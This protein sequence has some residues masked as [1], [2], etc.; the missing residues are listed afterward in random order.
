MPSVDGAQSDPADDS[1]TVVPIEMVDPPLG[2]PT[3]GAKAG[4][5]RGG[6]RARASRSS[7]GPA[8]PD[9]IFEQML[10]EGLV[11]TDAAYA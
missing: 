7:T 11:A 6:G 8:T 3:E 2:D 1:E 5:P 9:E 10:K 4:A